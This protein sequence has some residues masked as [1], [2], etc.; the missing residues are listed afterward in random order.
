ME[1]GRT[2]EGAKEDCTTCA[3]A[4]VGWSLFGVIGLVIS[5]MLMEVLYSELSAWSSGS[6]TVAIFLILTGC[7]AA[8]GYGIYLCRK[9]GLL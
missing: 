7:A 3:I 1:D 9:S 5:F 4:G 2:P 8:L 6:L